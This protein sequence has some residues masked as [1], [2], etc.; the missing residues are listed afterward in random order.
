MKSRYMPS[1]EYRRKLR[2]RHLLEGFCLINAALIFLLTLVYAL[3]IN[4]DLWLP[5]LI[6]VL[7][8]IMN[9][10]LSIRGILVKS[11]LEIIGFFITGSI[12]FGLL[13]YLNWT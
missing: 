13:A 4:R 6:A 3:D 9:Y 2:S 1:E 7:G 12:C 8:G 10:A 11:W 5:G